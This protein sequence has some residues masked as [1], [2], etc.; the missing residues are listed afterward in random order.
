MAGKESGSKNIVNPTNTPIR[1]SGIVTNT[2]A[3]CLYELKRIT[4]VPI[5]KN[6]PKKSETK[7]DCTDLAFSSFAP[8][9]SN[10]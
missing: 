4:S 2:R 8:Q 7:S 3:D 1:E 9:N 5:I 6:I 10:A